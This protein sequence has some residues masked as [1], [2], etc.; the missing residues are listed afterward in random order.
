MMKRYP[1]KSTMCHDSKREM[2]WIVK[3]IKVNKVRG[4]SQ[5]KVLD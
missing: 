2:I 4:K 5:E 3:K 1:G